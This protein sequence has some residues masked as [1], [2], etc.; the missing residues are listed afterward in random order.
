M[1]EIDKAVEEL[2]IVIRQSKEYVEYRYQLEKIKMQPELRSQI[3]AFREENFHLQN[4]TP[5]DQMLQKLE[6]FEE[7]Y[8]GLREN[9]LVNDFLTAEI[10]FCRRM[11]EV[12]F[13]ITE[14]LQ[15][16]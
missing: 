8:A 7:K 1:N 2:L 6:Q 11:Q 5:S 15:F 14:G 4:S 12:N 9:P 10:A 13:K 16:E 3:D